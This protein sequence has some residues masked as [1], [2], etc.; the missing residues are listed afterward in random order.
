FSRRLAHS[1]YTGKGSTTDKT[2]CDAWTHPQTPKGRAGYYRG[3]DFL[4]RALYAA[5]QSRNRHY[6]LHAMPMAVA[7]RLVGAGAAQ[8]LCRG[9][10]QGESGTGERRGLSHYLCRRADLGA[11]G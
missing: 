7:C 11:Q 6:L 3:P 8:Y 1:E 2:A 9:S 10:G 4:F 5:T